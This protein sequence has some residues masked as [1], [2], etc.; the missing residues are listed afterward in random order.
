MP[1]KRA[2]QKPKSDHVFGQRRTGPKMFRVGL[3]ARVSTDDQQT[4]PM[5]IRAM[6]EYAAKRGWTVAVQVKEI[7]S[8]ASQRQLRDQLLDAARRREVDVVLV[9]RL[10]RWGRSLPDLVT[11]LEELNHLGVG[12][13]SLTEALDL[14]TPTGRAMA[15]L[16]S[17]FAAFEHDVLRERVRAGLAEAR[18]KGKRLGRPLT[19][20]LHASQVRK[21]YR[22][23]VS[24]SEIARRLN[25]GRTSVRRILG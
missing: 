5:Q 13:V 14:T 9:W 18:L 21:L 15:G 10:D 6:R 3:Y 12:F 1:I 23:S 7:G 4:I 25:I 2:S 24:K 20:G 11:T 22:S 19:A 17:V 8:G 16:L